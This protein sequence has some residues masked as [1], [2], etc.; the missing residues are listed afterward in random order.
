MGVGEGCSSFLRG[1]KLCV[2]ACMC[3]LKLESQATVSLP[4]GVPGSELGPLQERDVLLTQCVGFWG[5][6]VMDQVFQESLGD[7]P[8]LLGHMITL[9]QSLQRETA[10]LS[11]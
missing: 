11:R 5:T 2:C 1:F 3:V 9:S 4:M 7:F 8:T 10:F 6:L